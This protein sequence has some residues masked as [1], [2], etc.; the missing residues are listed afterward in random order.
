MIQ[1]AAVRDLP[2][3]NPNA[4][5]GIQLPGPSTAKGTP[6]Y[7]ATRAQAVA[8][9]GGTYGAEREIAYESLLKAGVP[10]A[11]ARQAMAECDEY[12][13]SIGVGLDTPTRVPGNRR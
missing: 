9:R 11:Q 13:R 3:Y 1:D 12:F 6:H 2:G 5:P 4:A 10:E 8:G 7:A